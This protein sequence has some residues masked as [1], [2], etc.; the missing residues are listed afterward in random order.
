ML[1]MAVPVMMVLSDHSVSQAAP[2]ASGICVLEAGPFEESVGYGFLGITGYYCPP[3][4]S[5]RS[6]AGGVGQSMNKRQH[7]AIT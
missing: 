3:C 6:G 5:C 7:K 1:L 4:S 2:E